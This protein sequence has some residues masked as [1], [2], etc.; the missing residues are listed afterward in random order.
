MK[1]GRVS[2]QMM[3]LLA[4][5]SP[6]PA[7]AQSAAPAAESVADGSSNDAEDDLPWS[8]SLDGGISGADGDFGS[9]SYGLSLTRSIG[10]GYLSAS[11]DRSEEDGIKGVFTAA[12]SSTN[13]V[14]LAGG[15]P[16]GPISVDIFGS[17]G[18]TSFEIARFN[19]R[20]GQVLSLD[21]DGKAVS[22]GGSLSWGASIAES[23]S[24]SLS[25]S[26]SWSRSDMA[27]VL[28]GPLGNAIV[29]KERQSGTTGSANVTLSRMFGEEDQHSAS[30]TAGMVTTDNAAAFASSLIR[31]GATRALRPR[32]GGPSKDT[33]NDIGASMSLGLTDTLSL[34]LGATRTLG[35]KGPESV[36]YSAGLSFAF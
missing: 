35:A 34:D 28:A 33:W 13:T 5:A 31:S 12:P 10:D 16:L 22:L 32:L 11:V 36:S 21:G 30:L 24:L 1:P 9:K 18:W 14:T 29:R 3:A 27:R 6:L 17:L 4:A 19:R 20:N 2:S 26:V 15:H 7:L 8:I 23:T 25:G